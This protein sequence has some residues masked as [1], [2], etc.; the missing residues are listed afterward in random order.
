MNLLAGPPVTEPAN[1]RQPFLSSLRCACAAI[2]VRIDEPQ[3]ALFWRHFELL[4]ETNR[5]FNLTRITE[6]TD[7]AVKHYADAL[8]LLA[9][10]LNDDPNIRNVLDVG[11]GAG[12][13]AF[14]LAVMKP[15]WQV[16]A[17]DSTGKK[18]RFVTDTATELKIANLTGRHHR[19]GEKTDDGQRYD[20]LLYRAV[21][22]LAVCLQTAQGLVRRGGYVACYKGD[23]V[24][25][26]ERRE[27]EGA[28]KQTGF[29]LDTECAFSLPSPAG[30][31]R[32]RLLIFQHSVT[33][34]SGTR[35]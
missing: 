9:T 14:P 28:A 26:E 25:P 27:A 33:A 23:S 8:T 29:R 20:L 17:M 2:E 34:P 24:S 7:A 13:P 5:Q 10:R 19:A 22:K 3:E 32:R 12:F 11:S 30:E 16:T 6:P 15:E 1:D 35:L 4:V 18:A 21:A 31:I